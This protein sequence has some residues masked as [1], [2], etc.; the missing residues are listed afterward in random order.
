ML[1][2][3]SST[4]CSCGS[5]QTTSHHI[6]CPNAPKCSQGDLMKANDLA[7]TVA[8]HWRNASSERT[9]YTWL[10]DTK[11][12]FSSPYSRRRSSASTVYESD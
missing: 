7:I 9:A 4:L 6:E 2:A 8:K 5:L 12:E 10:P 1:P 3:N 11:F